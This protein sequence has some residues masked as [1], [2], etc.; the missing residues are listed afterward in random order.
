MDEWLG[1]AR[2]RIAA[3]T[4]LD[5][6]ELDLTDADVVALLDLARIAAHESGDR[7]NAPLACYLLGL[8]LGR[9]P[10]ADLARVAREGS[11]TEA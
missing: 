4:G 8:A 10:A 5:A 11:G 7:R 2:D 1:P 6:T 3:A 9:A